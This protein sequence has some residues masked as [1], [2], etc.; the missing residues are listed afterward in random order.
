MYRFIKTYYKWY[1]LYLFK[2][3]CRAEHVLSTMYGVDAYGGIITY[4][5]ALIGYQTYPC[6]CST[7]VV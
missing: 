3:N 2:K 4:A 5:A 1:V 7:G 6:P